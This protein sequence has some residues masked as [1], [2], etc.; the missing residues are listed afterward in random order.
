MTYSEWQTENSAKRSKLQRKLESWGLNQKQVISYFN[1]DNM[2][3]NQPDYCGLYK[4]NSKCHQMDNLNCYLCACP[5][6]VIHNPPLPAGKNELH[7]TCSISSRFAE[8]FTTDNSS[9]CDCTNCTIPHTEKAAL[10]NYEQLLPINDSC[11]LLEM[12]RGWQLTTILGKFK[13]F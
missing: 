1:Y 4:T 8:T 5:H 13:L 11:S 9:H 7:S 10:A 2:R 3:V 6:F 12:I